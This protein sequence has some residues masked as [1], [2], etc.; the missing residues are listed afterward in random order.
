MI[1]LFM[2]GLPLV[3]YELGRL[4]NNFCLEL[5]FFLPM[6]FSSQNLARVTAS[7]ITYLKYNPFVYIAQYIRS[8]NLIRPA[9]VSSLA[10]LPSPPLP[11]FR[12]VP[13]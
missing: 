12:E 9:C 8:H 6:G 4:A 10:P 7:H 13:S 2:I 11:R 3:G 5:Y 1:R